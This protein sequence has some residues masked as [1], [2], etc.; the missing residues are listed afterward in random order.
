MILFAV[1]ERG[2]YTDKSIERYKMNDTDKYILDSIKTWVWSGF[3]G[4]DE[5]DE[6]INDILEDEADEAFLR[7]AV[8]PEFERKLADEAA[9][10]GYTDCD[11]LD[12]AFETLNSSGIIA[13]Q[14]AGYTMTDGLSDVS[15]VQHERGQRVKGYCFYHGQDVERAVAGGGLVIGFG[16]LDNDKAKKAEIGN[17]VKQVLESTG[18]IVEWNGNTET[19]LNIPNLDWK[20][21]S[22]V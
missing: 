2:R 8:A 17:I 16:D 7:A 19:R 15:E 10:P 5:V 4:S 12:K 22:P 11:R 13:L 9:W 14:N 20:R 21:R 18:F 6:M 1:A 3:Y